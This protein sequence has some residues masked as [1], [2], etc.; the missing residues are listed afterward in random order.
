MRTGHHANIFCTRYMPGTG[1]PHGSSPARPAAC[2]LRAPGK[3]HP[4][5]EMLGSLDCRDL[6]DDSAPHHVHGQVNG[7]V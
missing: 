6:R 1:M 4:L 5:I 7:V 3:L 2:V